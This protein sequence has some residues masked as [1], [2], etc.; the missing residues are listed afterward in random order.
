MSDRSLVK[1]GFG[2]SPDAF[3]RLRVV[4]DLSDIAQHVGFD[5]S[6]RE[7]LPS[8]K[9]FSEDREGAILQALAEQLGLLSNF[10]IEVRPLLSSNA[11][12]RQ[13]LERKGG[14]H[15]HH[16]RKAPSLGKRPA[17]G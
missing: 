14:G 13:V 3:P 1:G 17:C 6:K 7:L 16:T 4:K 2:A 11:V 12:L 8:L 5:T 10:F 15:F 9:A